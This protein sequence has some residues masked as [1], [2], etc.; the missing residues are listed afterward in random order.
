MQAKIFSNYLQ[1]MILSKADTECL[2]LE[3]ELNPDVMDFF[4]AQLEMKTKQ[5]ELTQDREP[6]SLD[7]HEL[8]MAGEL[9]A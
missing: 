1:K 3:A 5:H 4:A 2:G 6:F 9:S 8:A 7:E